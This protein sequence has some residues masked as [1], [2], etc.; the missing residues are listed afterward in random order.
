MVS[1]DKSKI[2]RGAFEPN[3]INLLLETENQGDES[4]NFELLVFLGQI[5]MINPGF[6]EEVLRF[7]SKTFIGFAKLTIRVQS[8]LDQT[9]LTQNAELI[10]KLYNIHLMKIIFG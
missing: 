9:L 7:I 8:L 2:L 1:T 3:L 10:G 5:L 6:T 4:V